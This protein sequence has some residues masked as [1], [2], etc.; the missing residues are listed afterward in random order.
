MSQQA[1]AAEE[2]A[3]VDYDARIRQAEGC[4][5]IGLKVAL[6]NQ[7]ADETRHKEEIERILAGWNEL[8]LEPARNEER[9]QDDGGQ[10]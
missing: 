1:L 5:D 2:R 7:V 6:E 10:R 9:W 3:I 4:G 8:N